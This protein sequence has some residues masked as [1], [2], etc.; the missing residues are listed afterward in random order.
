MDVFRSKSALA[1]QFHD[2][3]YHNLGDSALLS[4]ADGPLLLSPTPKR[5]VPVPGA[6]WVHNRSYLF[7]GWH[8][9]KEVKSSTEYGGDVT[10]DFSASKLTP[11]PAH[12]RLFVPGMPGRE[13]SQALA[14]YAKEA[15]EPYDKAPTPVLVVRQNGEAWTR[16]FAAIF[17]ASSGGRNA[18]SVQSVTALD[19]GGSFAGFKVVSQI[20]L[21]SLTQYVLVQPSAV[22]VFEDAQLG[23]SFRGRYAIVTV[24][25]RDEC[26]SLYLGE[27]SR[28][29]FK[30]IEMTSVKGGSTAASAE[31]RGGTAT[32]TANAPAELV[33]PGGKRIAAQVMTAK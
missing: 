18:A 15:P 13:Y 24:N 29:R 6:V 21:H 12:M 22:S 7:P 8:V 9:F 19:G 5:F 14:P 16:P 27:G 23:I 33:L 28:L 25:D 30:G 3:V 4:G 20:N 11:S 1:H 10:V 2:Y 26:T 17:E 31:L 32:V